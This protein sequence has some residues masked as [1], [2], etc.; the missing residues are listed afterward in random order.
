MVY[1]TDSRI[2]Y[3]KIILGEITPTFAIVRVKI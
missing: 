2:Q 1:E 3:Y